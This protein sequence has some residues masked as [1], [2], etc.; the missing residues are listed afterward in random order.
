MVKKQCIQTPPLSTM[1][2]VRPIWEKTKNKDFM[3][4]ARFHV[5][6]AEFQS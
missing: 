6:T 5:K 1:L 4:T 3:E 2:T